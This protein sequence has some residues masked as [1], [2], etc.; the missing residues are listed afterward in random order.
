MVSMATIYFLNC[1]GYT[2]TRARSMQNF[3]RFSVVEIIVALYFKYSVRLKN[4]FKTK[5]VRTTLKSMSVSSRGVK[6]WNKLDKKPAYTP[7]F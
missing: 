4:N 3:R 1:F 5:Y 6:L 7:D 2:F